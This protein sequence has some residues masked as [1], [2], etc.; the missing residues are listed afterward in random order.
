V[1]G[2]RRIGDVVFGAP[3]QGVATYYDADGSGNCSFD[4][5]PNDLD[6]AAMNHAQYADSAACGA[7]VKVD[8]PN[9]TVTVRI[10][11][12]CPECPEGALDL[13]M[14]AF[15]KMADPAAGRVPITWKYVPCAVTGNVTYRYKDGSSQFWTAIQVENTKV[16]VAALAIQKGGAFVDVHRESY[17]YFV[18][19]A[20]AGSGNVV[21]RITSF[22]GQV[23]EDT[24]PAAASNVT[25]TGSG[26]F[27]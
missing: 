23:L 1:D 19:P 16:P 9:G 8:G 26:Q 7:C 13:S 14:S 24:L 25:A 5:T 4:A 20:G 3:V 18:D 15:A 22:D 10:V 27:R 17:D 2:G 11:D 6:V 21:V 12:Q